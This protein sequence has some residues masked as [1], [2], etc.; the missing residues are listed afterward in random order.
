[1]HTRSRAGTSRST[2]RRRPG[3]VGRSPRRRD[4]L[5]DH[6]RSGRRP[7]HRRAPGRAA[8]PGR[9][10]GLVAGHPHDHA[11]GREP[12]AEPRARRCRSGSSACSSSWLSRCSPWRRRGPNTSREIAG[13]AGTVARGHDLHA[14]RRRRA[15]VCVVPRRRSGNRAGRR[16]RPGLR[17]RAVPRGGRAARRSHR[18]RRRDAHARRPS[19]GARAASRSSTTSRSAIHPAAAAEYPHD[20][21]E[22][23]DEIVARRDR[24][25]LHPH[26]GPPARALLPRRER[27]HARS[28]ARGSS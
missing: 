8:L 27:P 9:Q 6:A 28:R 23:G 25:A 18:P 7:G 15:R 21:L 5:R 2:A 19:L 3:S 22:D 10:P 20:P 4:R 13:A 24:P 12:V 17:D 1:M 14:V 26:A 11:G 16:R